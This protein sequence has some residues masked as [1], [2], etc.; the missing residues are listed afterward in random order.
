VTSEHRK[1][2]SFFKDVV[3]VGSLIF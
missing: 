3:L 2:D 1:Q